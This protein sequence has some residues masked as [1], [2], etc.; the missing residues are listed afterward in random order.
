MFVHHFW[1]AVVT[2]LNCTI[3]AWKDKK[4]LLKSN[5]LKQYLNFSSIHFLCVFF[6]ETNH[7]YFYDKVMDFY[8][9][10][11]FLVLFPRSSSIHWLI[12]GGSQKIM[13]FRSSNWV[14]I[15]IIYCIFHEPNNQEWIADIRKYAFR[16]TFACARI[17]KLFSKVFIP[18]YSMFGA[19]FGTVNKT[20][21]WT[22]QTKSVKNVENITNAES[23]DEIKH[24]GQSW[25]CIL[26]MLVFSSTREVWVEWQYWTIQFFPSNAHT[27]KHF[28]STR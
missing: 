15:D 23:D 28:Q 20:L 3:L 18:N 12:K 11:D 14:S 7:R 6:I 17:D 10:L 8:G 24:N 19:C 22:N 27:I 21:R 26:D 4:S 5:K 16:V 13:Q 9:S 25:M 2:K 1:Y